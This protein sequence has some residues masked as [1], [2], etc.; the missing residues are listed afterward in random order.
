MTAEIDRLIEAIPIAADIIEAGRLPTIEQV[1]LGFRAQFE[2][3]GIELR[4][5]RIRE[6]RGDTTCELTVTRYGSHLLRQRFNLVSGPA[7]TSAARDLDRLPRPKDVE[8]VDWREVL[9]MSCLAILDRHRSGEPFNLVG[10]RAVT[11]RAS[12]RL[13]PPWLP[14]GRATLIYAPWGAGKSTLGAAIVVTL[15]RLEEII[16]GWPPPAE[17][18]RCLILDWESTAEEWN[19]RLALIAAGAGTGWPVEDAVMH[20][21]CRSPLDE[22]VE[23]VAEAIARNGIGFVLIDSAEKAIGASSGTE[24]YGDRAG[25][26]FEA[27]DRLGVT[28]VVLDHV[29]GEDMKRDTGRP[30]R[31]AIGSTMKGAWARAV[32]ELKREREPDEIAQRV[33]LVLHSA[34]V[35]D[36]PP[37]PPFEFAIVYD[38]AGIRFERSHVTA[39]DL[40]M[41][42]SKPERMTRVL[43]HGAKS[44]HAIATELEITEAHVRSIL[45]KDSGRRFVTL[46]DGSIGVVMPR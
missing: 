27:I 41:G 1:G 36:G 21:A 11:E 43:A 13:I 8:R 44:T 15:Q 39:P 23:K 14:L 25:R 40:A 37:L 26:L 22:Q 32:Y 5:E 30:I 28:T 24:S 6:S 2:D 19:D 18:V 33:E 35:N 17:P 3:L 45:S 20:R 34:K 10:H 38:D 31:K 4:I 16:P 12:R 29:A 42:L 46:P 9:E 7:R